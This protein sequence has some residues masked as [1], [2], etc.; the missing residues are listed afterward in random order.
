MIDVAGECVGQGDQ[1]MVAY[2]HGG[3]AIVRPEGGLCTK[4]H[5]YCGQ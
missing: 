1:V 3:P 4:F 2:R 5:E